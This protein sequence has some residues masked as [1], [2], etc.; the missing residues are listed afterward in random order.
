M[1]ICVFVIIHL[2]LPAAFFLP[3]SAD[4]PQCAATAA[5]ATSDVTAAVD[6]AVGHATASS[7]A[8]AATIDRQ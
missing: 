2:K 6:P 7:A 4:E 3:V 1:F 8:D 5:A